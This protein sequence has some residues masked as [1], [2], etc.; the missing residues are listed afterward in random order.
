MYGEKS[1]AARMQVVEQFAHGNLNVLISTDILSRGID[2]IDLTHV[3]N[4]NVPRKLEPFI[5]RI[6]RTGRAGKTGVALSFC[7][8]D[9]RSAFYRI[10]QSIEGEIEVM[11]W[12][13]FHSEKVQELTFEEAL[14]KV[15]KGRGT[16]IS[17]RAAEKKEKRRVENIQKIAEAA[18]KKAAGRQKKKK[19]LEEKYGKKLTGKGRHKGLSNKAKRKRK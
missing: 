11:D 13:P 17:D 12:H 4:Y 16:A 7:D 6:G 15:R 10:D 8:Q 3:I 1:N 2:V 19:D 5:H 14:E 9:D 18:R